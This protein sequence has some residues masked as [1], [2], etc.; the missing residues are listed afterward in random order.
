MAKPDIKLLMVT[1]SNNNKF[2][3]MHDNND[4]TFTAHWGRVGVEGKDTVYPISK[5][6]STLASKLKKGYKDV[7]ANT[8]KICEYA[9]VSD[10]ELNKLLNAFLENSRQYVS[11]FTESTAISD[12]AAANAQKEI[13]LLAKN[14]DII[15][16]DGET[17][18]SFNVHLL[19]L[20]EII[21]RKM[22][23]VQDSLCHKLSDR[24]SHIAREQ[25]LLDNL[26]N[27][28]KNAP[29]ASGTQTIEDA[30]GFSITKCTPAE[31][32]YIKDKL[33]KDGF[34]RYKF[35]RAWKISNPNREKGFEEYLENNNLKNDDNNVK[36]YWH[37]TGSEN[38]LSILAN[39]L[40][41]KPSN[42][43]YCGSMYGLGIYNAPNADKAAGY[44]SITGSYWKGGSSNVAYMFINAVIMGKQYDVK[45]NYERY[46]GITIRNLDN[47]KFSS[48]NLGYHSVYAHAGG[49]LKRDECIVYNQNQ[50][51]CRYLVEFKT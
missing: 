48:A 45:D 47:D 12:D 41:I 29:K 4:G 24:A 33:N 38:I 18:N 7:T 13:N 32:D 3:N 1:D 28:T 51:A 49:Y 20:F 40:L 30:F 19:K 37:G 21:P 39:G 14:I 15:N 2:Y 44:T 16:P 10:A 31:I 34:Y 9:P 8:A 5:W 25:S 43:S 36:M 35:N 23:R 11:H 22:T 6:D 17:L 42:A 26:V 46:N 50:V 27:M